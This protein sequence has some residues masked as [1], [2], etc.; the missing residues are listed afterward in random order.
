MKNISK[1][2]IDKNHKLK[3]RIFPIYKIKRLY[4]YEWYKCS[5][6]ALQTISNIF[7]VFMSYKSWDWVHHVRNDSYKII[8][9]ISYKIISIILI[10]YLHALAYSAALANHGNIKSI[11]SS[12]IHVN[13]WDRT[14]QF[15]GL[16]CFDKHNRKKINLT[17]QNQLTVTACA[18]SS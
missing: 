10:Y 6:L 13:S 5:Q 2:F 1:S 11:K 3:T 7:Y 16:V 4:K 12:W 15:C 14:S 8:S 9:I 17:V 18:V